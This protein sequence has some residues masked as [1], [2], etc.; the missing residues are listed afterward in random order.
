MNIR[1]TLTVAQIITYINE[2]N[3]KGIAV[4][5]TIYQELHAKGYAYA[6]WAD[7]VATGDAI[8]G[9]A[10]LDF[11]QS[12]AGI[13]MTAAQITMVRISMLTG[14][15]KSLL[16]M[17]QNNND[18]TNNDVSYKIARNFHVEAFT[19][20]GLTIDNW[21]LEAPMKVVEKYLGGEEKVEKLWVQIRETEGTYADAWAIS[22]NLYSMMDDIAKFGFI[23][24]NKSWEYLPFNVVMSA[25]QIIPMDVIKITIS[26]TEISIAE[27]W[28]KSTFRIWAGVS[29]FEQLVN[30]E[31]VVALVGDEEQS[32]QND[33]IY[34]LNGNILG[35]HAAWTYFIY[36]LGGADKLIG[37]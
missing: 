26:S 30:S 24:L 34:A 9:Q 15:L 37:L 1:E 28:V 29:Y 6:G 22:A 14:Y 20:N 7:G 25:D 13:T 36:G 12:S 8:T 2:L 3:D 18:Q 31:K 32:N 5:S 10:A 4:V 21:T 17:A 27:L 35:N 16:V 33:T 11:M 19:K 23:F